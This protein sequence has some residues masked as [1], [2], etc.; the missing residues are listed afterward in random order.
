MSRQIEM[1]VTP[2]LRNAFTCVFTERESRR[3]RVFGA[4]TVENRDGDKT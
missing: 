2:L 1:N 4:V 3:E